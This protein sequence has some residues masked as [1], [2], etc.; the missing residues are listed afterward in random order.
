MNHLKNKEH[1]RIS[2]CKGKSLT[3]IEALEML[4]SKRRREADDALKKAKCAI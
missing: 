2:L 4:I 1:S 3:G